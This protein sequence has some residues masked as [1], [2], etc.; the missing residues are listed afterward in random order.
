[1]EWGQPHFQSQLLSE[2]TQNKTIYQYNVGLS[3]HGV[4]GDCGECLQQRKELMENL[5][6][7]F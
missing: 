5:R 1:M 6:F 7:K 3:A 4:A 2:L